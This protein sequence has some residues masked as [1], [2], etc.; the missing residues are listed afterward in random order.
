MLYYTNWHIMVVLCGYWTRVKYENYAENETA[1][2]IYYSHDGTVKHTVKVEVLIDIIYEWTNSI[3]ARRFSIYY[4]H[5][6]KPT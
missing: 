6:T 5:T 2:T 1:K 3:N 4:L